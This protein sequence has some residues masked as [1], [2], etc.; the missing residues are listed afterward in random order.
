MPPQWAQTTRGIIRVR[1]TLCQI[2]SSSSSIV[3]RYIQLVVH[4]WHDCILTPAAKI[5]TER[6]RLA[7]IEAEKGVAAATAVAGDKV[8]GSGDSAPS[9]I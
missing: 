8:E 7:Q 4:R 9:G 2:P 1:A 6:I 3:Q 5:Q